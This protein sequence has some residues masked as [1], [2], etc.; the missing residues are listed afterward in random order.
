M[1]DAQHTAPPFC[2]SSIRVRY[3]ECDPMGVAHHAAYIPWL[4]IGRTD[5]LRATGATYASLEAAGTLLVVVELSIRYRRAIRYD[6]LLEIRTR[7]SGG[8]RVK[9]FHEYEVIILERDASHGGTPHP[10]DALAATATTTLGCVD[11]AGAI[12]PL[13][14]WLVWQKPV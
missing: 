4:E 11:R 12:R 7:W 9:I 1:H 10:A 5:L 8:G 14:D 2:T 13:P 3:C 6:D